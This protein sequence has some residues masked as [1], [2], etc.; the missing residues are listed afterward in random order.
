M[1]SD[2]GRKSL[3]GAFAALTSFP[4]PTP[5]GVEHPGPK[6]MYACC[7][8]VCCS[9]FY[10]WGH[11]DS[12]IWCPAG[13]CTVVSAD[14]MCYGIKVCVYVEPEQLLGRWAPFLKHH[15]SIRLP[16]SSRAHLLYKLALKRCD[17]R[18]TAPSRAEGCRIVSLKVLAAKKGGSGGGSGKKGVG[19]KKGS[20]SLM[21]PPKPE[22]PYLQTQ[23]IIQNLLLIES[24]Y[25]KTGR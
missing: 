20:S 3:N 7:F 6:I 5:S 10:C 25:R 17:F 9:N 16:P 21:T 11:I 24:Y 22:Q 19:Q 2:L 4:T 12:I 18:A 1:T 8:C 15:P 13:P 23:I 14:I